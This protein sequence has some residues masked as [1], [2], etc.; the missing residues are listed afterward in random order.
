MRIVLPKIWEFSRSRGCPRALS[1]PPCVTTAPADFSGSWTFSYFLKARGVFFG[2]QKLKHWQLLPVLLIQPI[3]NIRQLLPLSK[4]IILPY[5]QCFGE[6][7][8]FPPSSVRQAEMTTTENGVFS[9]YERPEKKYK[10]IC[11]L[12]LQKNND[13]KLQWILTLYVI[14]TLALNLLFQK[15]VTAKHTSNLVFICISL[16]F[17]NSKQAKNRQINSYQYL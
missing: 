7:P 2:R 15:W 1:Q 6:E 8:C 10:N 13:N 5:L 3:T 14:L 11:V 9:L 4:P 17:R 12:Q 16:Y